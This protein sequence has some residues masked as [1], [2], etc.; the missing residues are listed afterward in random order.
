MATP[1]R[2]TS[3]GTQRSNFSRTTGNNL[4]DIPNHIVTQHQL[5]SHHN[6]LHQAATF[7]IDIDFHIF[8]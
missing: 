8:K 6:F 5:Q 4:I 2:I 7:I 1:Y 3:G